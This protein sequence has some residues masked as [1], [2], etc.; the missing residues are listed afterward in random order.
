MPGLQP[1]CRGHGFMCQFYRTPLG[2]CQFYRTTLTLWYG[3]VC[4]ANA[5]MRA[6]K[7]LPFL[8]H[9]VSATVPISRN[10]GGS[11]IG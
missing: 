9:R 8:C 6:S 2:M 11:A 10:A 1:H 5:F 4:R 7:A 3:I